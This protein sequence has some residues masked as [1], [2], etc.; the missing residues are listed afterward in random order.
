MRPIRFLA[1]L[2]AVVFATAA[3]SGGDAGDF[4]VRPRKQPRSP[5]STRPPT[6]QATPRPTKETPAPKLDAK[7][8]ARLNQQLIAAA[9][10]NDVRRARSLIAR[11]ADVNAKDSTVQSAYLISTSEGYLE[12]LNLTLKHGADVDSK[13]S[14][15]GTGL[16][17]AADRGHADIAGRL[18]QAGVE[19][20]HI[21]NLGW[22]ALHEAIILGDGSGRYVDTVRVL[23][24]AGAD[25]RLR[26][27]RDQ[28]TPIEHATSKGYREIAQ[29]LRAAL[30]ADRPSKQQAN[31][32]LLAAAERG[33]ATAAAL[34]IR[35]GA[36]L[37]T[38]DDKG[39]TPLL[40]AATEDRL[41][42][43]RLLVYLGADPDALDDQHD[44]P[45]LVTGV[46]GSV[47][48]LEVLLLAGPDLTIRN[49]F[50]GTSLIPASERGHVAYVRRAVRTDIEVNHVNNLG[51]TA[52]L[53]A[54]IL[55]DGSRR[56]QQ[57]VT[58]LLDA[59]AD[60]KITDRQGVT[61]LQH[62]ERRG[63]REVARILRNA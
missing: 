57:I 19:I 41:A 15:N 31:R 34:A 55:G 18:V 30:E 13:D 27:Q 5:A 51:W 45:W 60:P 22:T 14:F 39:R 17:R 36:S 3:C 52:L 6:P 44:T 1:V 40:L 63:Q 58:T 11:G 12:L 32:R 48:M 35:A 28:I 62:A 49:R 37:E 46:T 2:T 43:A 7:E 24:A 26:S 8:Q 10:D 25:L 33:D 20:D 61:A 42:V 23:V 50:G 29:V 56:Y 38:R 47:D 4:R 16:I 9:W 21:N 54:V 59:G 53:E